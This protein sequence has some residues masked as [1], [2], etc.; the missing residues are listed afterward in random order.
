[1]SKSISYQLVTDLARAH[2]TFLPKLYIIFNCKKFSYC[3]SL[4][5]YY[6]NYPIDQSFQTSSC[7]YGCCGPAFP[8]KASEA[9]CSSPNNTWLAYPIVFISL[10]V[11][12]SIIYAFCCTKLKPSISISF[13]NTLFSSNVFYSI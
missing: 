11:T 5:L 6:P 3:D 12:G 8:S 9:C 1:M 10:L 2:K 13:L 7:S 4:C